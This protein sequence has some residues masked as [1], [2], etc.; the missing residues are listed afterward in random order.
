M[1]FT[2]LPI[3]GSYLIEEESFTD[4]RGSFAETWENLKY[5]NNGIIFS[6]SNSCLSLNHRKGTLR[7]LHYQEEPFGQSKLVSCATGSIYD[8]ILDLRKG[9]PSYK[10]WH[11]LG[12]SAFDGKAVYIPK[13]CAHGFI[14]HVDGSVVSY[15]IEGEYNAAAAKAIRWNDPAFGIEWPTYDLIMSEKDKNMSNYQD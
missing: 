8:V 14:T 2:Q 5:S 3:S 12:L 9:S 15:L 10:Q 7:G 6:P 11:A 4:N 1:K 13:G